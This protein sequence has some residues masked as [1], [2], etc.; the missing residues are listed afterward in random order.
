LAAQR[1]KNEKFP[2]KFPVSREF[3]VCEREPLLWHYSGDGTVA[4]GADYVSGGVSCFFTNV[5]ASHVT[6]PTDITPTAVPVASGYTS[7]TAGQ[8]LS[9]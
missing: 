4:G 5:A 1:P 8:C 9:F 6:N 7:A 3:A 2:V